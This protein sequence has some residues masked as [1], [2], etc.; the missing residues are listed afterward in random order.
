MLYQPA[1]PARSHGRIPRPVAADQTARRI[2]EPVSYC[3][4]RILGPELELE[5]AADLSIT[6]VK[7]MYICIILLSPE[8]PMSHNEHGRYSERNV[9]I[10]PLIKKLCI[11]S[12]SRTFHRLLDCLY[13]LGEWE[14]VLVYA[15][16]PRPTV[17]S[18]CRAMESQDN[19]NTTVTLVTLRNTY[20]FTPYND[21]M[22]AETCFEN[23][24]HVPDEMVTGRCLTGV[25]D[26]SP[27]YNG[28][29]YL[30]I[31]EEGPFLPQELVA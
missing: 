17:V 31:Q 4:C 18:H 25:S 9:F 11:L 14:K 13:N 30:S 26:Q 24:P 21:A 10:F 2:R 19:S 23:G 8:H 12:N 16:I 7:I 6:V 5:F 20:I 15:Y 27:P 3:S 22:P 28:L 1:P 29:Q